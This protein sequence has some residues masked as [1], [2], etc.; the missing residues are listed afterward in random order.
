MFNGKTRLR[1]V[2][3]TYTKVVAVKQSS[4][5]NEL[6]SQQGDCWG[7]VNASRK[8]AVRIL[9][10]MCN[11]PYSKELGVL[12]KEIV[13]PNCDSRTYEEFLSLTIEE[14][15]YNLTMTGYILD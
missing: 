11:I 2:Y 7:A 6:V 5:Y 13:S 15:L 4:R 9:V 8:Y 3:R 12:F 1:D 10:G 14:G